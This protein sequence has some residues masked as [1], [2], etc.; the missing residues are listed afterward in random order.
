MHV[1][2]LGSLTQ[3]IKHGW[4]LREIKKLQGSSRKKKKTEADICIPLHNLH[5]ID[6]IVKC[7]VEKKNNGTYKKRTQCIPLHGWQRVVCSV[8]QWHMNTLLN[9]CQN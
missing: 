1:S 7:K 6:S 3:L 2:I 8:L 4:L 5:I 9:R